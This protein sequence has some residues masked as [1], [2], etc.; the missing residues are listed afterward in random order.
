MEIGCRIREE[1]NRKK[2]KGKGEPSV[3]VAAMKTLKM[4]SLAYLGDS[5]L[6]VNVSHRAKRIQIVM[7]Y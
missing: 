3:W 4:E 1:S 7:F 5:Y 2:R 6:D